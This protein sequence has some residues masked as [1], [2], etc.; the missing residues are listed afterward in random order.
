[1]EKLKAAAPAVALCEKNLER[2]LCD[3]MKQIVRWR[4]KS[5]QKVFIAAIG[6]MRDARC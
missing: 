1:M 3:L 5:N 6:V 2:D 4:K